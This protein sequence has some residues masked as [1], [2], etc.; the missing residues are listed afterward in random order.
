[1]AHAALA[2]LAVVFVTGPVDRGRLVGAALALGLLLGSKPSAPLPFALLA[3]TLA[4]RSGRQWP[5]ALAAVAA[6]LVLGARATR[7]AGWSTATR[8]GRWRCRRGRSR[9]QGR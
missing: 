4:I 2:V 1:M 5:G 7:A 9:C 3:A 6:A 8:C